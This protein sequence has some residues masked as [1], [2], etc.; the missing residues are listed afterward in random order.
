MATNP[1]PPVR[2]NFIDDFLPLNVIKKLNWNPVS[3]YPFSLQIGEKTPC[4]YEYMELM[5]CIQKHEKTMNEKCKNKYRDF[6]L[7][8][9]NN[10]LNTE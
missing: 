9:S 1:L 7:C 5:L 3:P 8:L 10:G 4:F 2:L 6:L